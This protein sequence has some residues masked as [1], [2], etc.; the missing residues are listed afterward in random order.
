VAHSQSRKKSETVPRERFKG[1]GMGGK[2]SKFHIAAP[3]PVLSLIRFLILSIF[4]F[5]ILGFPFFLFPG[6]V[7]NVV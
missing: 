6:W 2:Y 7:G 5:S 4:I 3:V 1:E